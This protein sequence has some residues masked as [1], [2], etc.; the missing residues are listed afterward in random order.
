MKTEILAILVGI[1]YDATVI[2]LSNFE[3]LKGLE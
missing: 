1:I 2:P 3:T